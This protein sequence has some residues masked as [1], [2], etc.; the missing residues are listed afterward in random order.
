MSRQSVVMFTAYL[1]FYKQGKVKILKES[2]VLDWTTT[3][4]K[5][6]EN[7]G[8]LKPSWAFVETKILQK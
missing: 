8:I 3:R 4:K 7:K 6:S 2:I 5:L 1:R